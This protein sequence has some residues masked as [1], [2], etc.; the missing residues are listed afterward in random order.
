MTSPA[1]VAV[2]PAVRL[3]GHHI[4]Y[5]ASP[6]MHNA[7]FGSLGLPVRYELE[8][9][10]P[11]EL[12]RAVERLRDDACL[13][14]N[15]T[16]PHKVRVGELVDEVS[17]DAARVGA[18]NTIV[19][20]DGR[21]VGHNTDLPALVEELR[22]LAATSPRAVV[23][24]AG[25][26]ARAVLPALEQVGAADVT[27]VSRRGDHTWDDLPDLLARADLL[28]NA[29]PVGTGTDESPVAAALLRAD[30]A[31]LDLVYR[32]S[33]TRL[34]RDARRAGAR[35]HAGARVLLGQGVRSLELWL[36][37]AA[38]LDVMRDALR[39]ELGTDALE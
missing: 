6:V 32:P 29:T 8:D 24:G 27:V 37:R 14:G 31:V 18:V 17:A 9:V 2:T 4:A 16:T 1:S 23:L 39:S 19:R 33:P 15:V 3:L 21:L 10:A 35:A 7:A 12:E 25:G 28:V 34:V 30:L 11:E 26:A 13:G 36:E 38:P 22:S 20:R 5:S